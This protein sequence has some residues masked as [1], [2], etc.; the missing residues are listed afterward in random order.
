[1]CTVQEAADKIGVIEYTHLVSSSVSMPLSISLTRTR[2]IS[3]SDV[4]SLCSELLDSEINKIL[5][6][7]EPAHKP[8]THR[9]SGSRRPGNHLMVT[10]VCAEMYF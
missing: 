6:T 10:C 1:M 3:L 8:S 7:P 2:T 5:E 9:C 4:L